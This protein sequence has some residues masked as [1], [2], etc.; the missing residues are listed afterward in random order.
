MA[1]SSSIISSPDPSFIRFWFVT[2]DDDV[3]G[4]DLE[5]IGLFIDGVLRDPRGW[6]KKGYR[7]V[8]VTVEDGMDVR[9]TL[10]GKRN[11]IHIRISSEKTINE[12][13]RFTGLS[14]ADMSLNVIYFNEDR[15]KYGSIESGLDIVGYRT[16]ICFHEAGHILGRDHYDCQ[17]A[18]RKCPVMYQQTISKGCCIPNPFPLDWE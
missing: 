1:F 13:C 4:L 7:F 16:Y 18:N 8:R 10:E 5:E 9:R 2:V 14:C 3:S 11:V 17:G 6:A 12:T 15:W